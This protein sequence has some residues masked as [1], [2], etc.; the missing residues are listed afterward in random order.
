MHEYWQFQPANLV[1]KILFLG[2]RKFLPFVWFLHLIWV[3]F[4]LTMWVDSEIAYMRNSHF[5]IHLFKILA[6]FLCHLTF[7][8]YSY[9]K[10]DGSEDEIIRIQSRFKRI[11]EE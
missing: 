2:K 5:R 1:F 3:L 4:Y 10:V 6:N 11:S 7:P 9:V 8:S